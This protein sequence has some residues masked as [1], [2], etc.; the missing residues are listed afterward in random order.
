MRSASAHHHLHV[1]L[2]G[3]D[4]ET[5]PLELQNQIDEARNGALVDAAG[6]LVHQD[7]ARLHGKPAGKLEP[8]ALTR[9]ELAREVVALLEK[10]DEGQRFESVV[11]RDFHV[12]GA[13]QRADDDV[14][15][16]REVRE[17]FELLE[18][19]GHAQAGDAVG[20]QAGDVA[21]VEE[22]TAGVERLKPGDQIEQRGFAGAV[23][24]DD[25][26]DL[27]LVHVERDVGIGGEAAVALGQAFDVEQQAHAFCALRGAAF[28]LRTC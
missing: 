5:A 11:A 19:A 23:G 3:D 18:R 13:G 14:L 16:H 17:G 4:G 22:D 1:V 27:A 7:E 2:D 10:I 12:G 28:A 26:D 9:G 25:A 21:P 15:G 20:P 24:A 8:L 6:H